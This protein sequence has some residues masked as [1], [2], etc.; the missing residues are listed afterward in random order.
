[1]SSTDSYE[2]GLEESRECPDCDK[3]FDDEEEYDCHR[4]TTH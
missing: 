2:N 4:L 3:W 1:M